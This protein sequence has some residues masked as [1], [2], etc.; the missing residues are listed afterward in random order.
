M[1]TNLRKTSIRILTFAAM[2]AMLASLMP[3]NWQ[4]AS[5]ATRPSNPRTGGATVTWDCVWFGH[6]PQ[7]ANK[8]GGFNNDRI[9]WRVLS[10]NG[11][12][13]LLLA[14]KVLDGGAAEKGIMYNENEDFQNVTWETATIRSWLNGYGSSANREGKDYSANNFVNKAF[15]SAEKA[16][17]Y[18]SV[19][20]NPNNPKYKTKGG[21]ATKDKIFLLSI[22]EATNPAYGFP[23]KT[24]TSKER[25]AKNTAYVAQKDSGQIAYDWWWLR[26]PGETS[27]TAVCVDLLGYVH[28]YGASTPST[29]GVRPA[30]RLN[31]NSTTWQNAGT[32]SVKKAG[33]KK[34][35]LKKAESK[36]K[37]TLKLT[38]KRNAQATGYQAMV[39]TDKK[40]KKNKKTALIKKNKTVTKT[41]K[42]L[43]KGKTYYAKVRA[44]KQYGKTKLYGSYSKAKK[45]KVK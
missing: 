40:F 1:N 26:S 18:E 24:G 32:V 23:K 29:L 22:G 15:S 10:V 42:K 6:Y 38:W 21:N 43:K 45:A 30:I 20:Q 41:F 5:A 2:F 19:V 35:A 36:K 27:D 37:G 7:S 34:V 44:Y 8:K 16:A 33:P 39:S 25:K 3:M 4:Q 11:D 9:K 31:L 13:A 17:I 12:E 28:P 14:N